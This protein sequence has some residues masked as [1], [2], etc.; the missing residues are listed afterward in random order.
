MPVLLWLL[1]FGL[2]ATASPI[3]FLLA[4]PLLLLFYPSFIADT[5]F[6]NYRRSE[7]PNFDDPSAA[8]V[9][10]VGRCFY[11][12]G[13]AGKLGVWHLLP[14]ALMEKYKEKSDK[15]KEESVKKES[16]PVIFY[17]HGN[18]FDRLVIFF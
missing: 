4:L 3:L 9:K 15:E 14:T 18:S 2:L 13:E 6:M 7:N 12:Q 8:E 1:F 11:L 10:T 17:A 5:F 16:Y